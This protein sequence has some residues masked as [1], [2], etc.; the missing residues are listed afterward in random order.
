[1]RPEVPLQLPPAPR[2]DRNLLVPELV[3]ETERDG[4]SVGRRQAAGVEVRAPHVDPE[5]AAKFIST[6]PDAE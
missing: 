4:Q 3:A 6:H 2:A 5:A 1:M